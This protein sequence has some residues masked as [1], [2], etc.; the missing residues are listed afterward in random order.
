MEKKK[1]KKGGPQGG[2]EGTYA[3]EDLG[4]GEGLRHETLD[5]TGTLDGKLVGLAVWC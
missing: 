5:L 3:S 4:D 1:K 2:W